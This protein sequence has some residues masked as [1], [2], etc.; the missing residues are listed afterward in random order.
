[1]FLVAF[2][3]E[4]VNASTI[5]VPTCSQRDVQTGINEASSGDTV[6][7][8]AGSCTWTTRV[9]V[10]GKRLTL[11]GAG[12]GATNITDGVSGGGSLDVDASAANF[13]DV[14]GFTFI[15]KSISSFG[16]VRI[17]GTQGEVA[18]RFHHNRLFDN[19]VAGGRGLYVYQVYGLIDH[20]AF[21]VTDTTA[22]DQMLTVAGSYVSTDG[23]FTPWTQPLT[24]GTDKAV[25]VEDSSFTVANQNESVIDAYSG[26]RL[27]V[28]R[29]TFR[30]TEVGFHGT[31]SG[32]M[33]S[34]VS[35]EMYANSFVNN[36]TRQQRAVTHRG[37]TGLYFDNTFGGIRAWH[38]FNLIYYRAT[39]LAYGWGTADGT[40]YDIGSTDTAANESR[41]TV[42]YG[43]GAR[44]L[45]SNPDKT[46]SGPVGGD[47]T[48]GFDG[49]GLRGYPAR[50][51][52]GRGPNGQTLSP[53]YA[54]NNGGVAIAVN[55]LGC[56]LCAGF[57]VSTWIAENRDFY[58]H[59]PS[60]FNGTVGVGRG[61]LANRPTTCQPL[62]A[63]FATDAGPNG[64]LFQCRTS[65]TW[66]AYYS[67][68][69]Y[70]HP[71]QRGKPAPPTNLKIVG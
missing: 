54:W 69:T 43:T 9:T 10:T 36:S 47:C 52:P 39:Q 31:D 50:D 35:L 66:T 12:I 4:R 25:Y 55:D 1:M 51:Q 16:M 62:T 42:P 40:K 19:G 58:N 21:D 30:D 57:P 70:P 44:F 20:V 46:C 27:V 29:N 32:G 49:S 33:R 2:S 14:N 34:T 71:L 3:E 68:Y 11:I 45:A 13:V 56:A 64:T 23:G 59:V 67:P 8:P 5:R 26:A 37:G 6:I 17:S 7:V 22:S 18:F 15:K 24:F 65:N 53:V 48:R 41:F 61:V 60:G 28:R 38:G 63:Y